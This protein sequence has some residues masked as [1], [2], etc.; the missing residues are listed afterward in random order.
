[1]TRLWACLLILIV[2]GGCASPSGSERT[3]E[4]LPQISIPSALAPASRGWTEFGRSV[5]GRPL[6]ARTVGQGPLRVL[7]IG[8]IHGSEREGL[9]ALDAILA[10]LQAGDSA[11]RATIRVVRDANPDGTD[12][13]RR[14]NA[15]RVDLNRNWPASSYRA[16]GSRGRSALSEP[17]TAALAREIEGFDPHIVI[18]FH[19]ISSGPFVNYDGSAASLAGAFATAAAR[20][21]ARWR[22]QP[23]MG[24]PTPGS[25][26]AYIGVDQ[27]KPILT[28]EFERGQ[29]AES[30]HRA[31][32]AGIAAVVSHRSH[33][34][35]R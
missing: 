21:D 15:N 29:S 23:N 14:T 8:G 4:P 28:I 19:S 35:A 1:M 7:L 5:E 22:V 10:D 25:L 13:R 6:L 26:G 9:G 30:A 11:R 16:G 34:S 2:V 24:Y 3:R 18:V 33:L 27:G 20:T 32:S 17:E 12:G 31:A